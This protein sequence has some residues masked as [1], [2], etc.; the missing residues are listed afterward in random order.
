MLSVKAMIMHVNLIIKDPNR[1]FC[2]LCTKIIEYIMHHGQPN[3]WLRSLK[4]VQDPENIYHNWSSLLGF[5][6]VQLYLVIC[7]KVLQSMS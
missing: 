1:I 7:D 6:S 5:W 4:L 2:A 3:K